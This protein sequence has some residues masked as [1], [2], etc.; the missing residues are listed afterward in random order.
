MPDTT[1]HAIRQQ[2]IEF[3]FEELE[4]ITKG[5]QVKAGVHNHGLKAA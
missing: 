3:W 1:V 2:L 4:K 5:L